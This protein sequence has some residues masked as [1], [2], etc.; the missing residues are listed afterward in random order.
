MHLAPHRHVH[1]AVAPRHLRLNLHI[2]LRKRQHPADSTKACAQASGR[3]MFE[4]NQT[5]HWLSA[6]GWPSKQMICQ[7]DRGASSILN[8]DDAG[9]KS[10]G[11]AARPLNCGMKL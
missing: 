9:S 5:R 6:P 8:V 4:K 7:G 11:G 2:L 3:D 10:F 1:A